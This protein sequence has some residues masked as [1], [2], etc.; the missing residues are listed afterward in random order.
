MTNEM[1]DQLVDRATAQNPTLSSYTQLNRFNRGNIHFGHTIM[2]M[3]STGFH[4]WGFVVYR[5]T[6]DDDAAWERFL[7]HMKQATVDKLVRRGQSDLL[8]QYLSWTIFPD[9]SLDDQLGDAQTT[10]INQKH[11]FRQTFLQ[12]SQ[13]RSVERDGPGADHV[14]TQHLPRFNLC[15]LVDGTCLETFRRWERWSEAGMV[16]MEP[17]VAVVLLD[18]R[19][20]EQGSGSTG[21]DDI[22]G[23]TR[24]YT[25]WMYADVG[26]LPG[27]YNT[28]HYQDLAGGYKEYARP[29]LVYPGHQHGETV[30]S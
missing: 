8:E 25:G 12:W 11:R 19:C 26:S 22:E 3:Q 7:E 13:D 21:Y 14:D 16:G 18:A 27:L 29:P 15:V 6:C 4:T 10:H 5:S 1:A 28:L 9:S 24:E 17:L 30:L 23:C 2:N 20:D